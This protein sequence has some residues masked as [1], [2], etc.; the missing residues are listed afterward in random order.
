[1]PIVANK[2]IMQIEICP[3]WIRPPASHP[4]LFFCDLFNVIAL[5]LSS[6]ATDVGQ[7]P[8][9][10]PEALYGAVRPGLHQQRGMELQSLVF[11]TIVKTLSS[12]ERKRGGQCPSLPP[13]TPSLLELRACLVSKSIG[14]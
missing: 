11:T 4:P 12:Q 8:Q 1:M 7:K 10:K 6:Q 9:P 2:I 14:V 5:S 13:P 3:F